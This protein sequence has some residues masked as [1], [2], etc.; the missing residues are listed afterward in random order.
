MV[1]KVLDGLAVSAGIFERLHR[2]CCELE[3]N[4]VCPKLA[5][6]LVGNNPASRSYVLSKH[7]DCNNIGIQSTLI[8]LP[9][10]T[11]EKELISKVEIL[12]ASSDVSGIIVQLPLPESID[13]N[14]VIEAIN[15]DKDADGLHPL[16][17]G[18]LVTGKQGIVPCT[19]AG[20]VK[21]LEAHRITLEG[22]TIA[23]IGRGTTV[24][25]P[26]GILL[27][28][29]GVNAT[30]I[31]IHSRSRNI[32][33]LS[34]IADVVV[35]CAG[36]K[37]IVEPSWIKPGAVVV[38][39]GI[40]QSGVSS[41]GKMILTGDVHPLTKNI[42]SYI[43]PVVGGVGPMTRAML[44]SNVINLSERDFRKRLYAS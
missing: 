1:A 9:A 2:A 10:N 40:N 42:A 25:R 31:N 38:D 35:A 6:V 34:R 17:L 44:M 23:V 30:V 20:I 22:K 4:G 19:P 14:K 32:S 41:S 36:V 8:E 29:K 11:S 13:Q 26:L 5:T 24:G 37:H 18:Y 21:L 7:R 16:N 15:P 28:G 43:S 12:N 33:G 39:V 27:S 3:N